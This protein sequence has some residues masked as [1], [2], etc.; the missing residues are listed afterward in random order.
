MPSSIERR[1]PSLGHS[2]HEDPQRY[3]DGACKDRAVRLLDGRAFGV[4]SLATQVSDEHRHH[5]SA[6]ESRFPRQV[7]DGLE[8]AAKM[9]QRA[10][11]ANEVFGG[12][13]EVR[14]SKGRS[15]AARRSDPRRCARLA[16][17]IDV[18]MLG[19]GIPTHSRK[20]DSSASEKAST[21]RRLDYRGLYASFFAAL[22]PRALGRYGI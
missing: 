1:P 20:G 17:N 13:L 19:L 21:S 22:L 14:G 9:D 4:Q 18:P 6:H 7:A 5:P 12:H 10:R 16:L 15:S 8:L 2:V 11:V 3:D